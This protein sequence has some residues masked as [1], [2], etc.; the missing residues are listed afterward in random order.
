MCVLIL[1]LSCGTLLLF[2]AMLHLKRCIYKCPSHFHLPL[3]P[4]FENTFIQTLVSISSLTDTLLRPLIQG[5][6]KVLSTLAVTSVKWIPPIVTLSICHP[7]VYFESAHCPIAIASDDE[8]LDAIHLLFP[9]LFF[10]EL[11][12]AV[13]NLLNCTCNGYFV[14]STSPRVM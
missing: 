11:S 7:C 2:G 6:I 13:Y 12:K 8:V 9:L 5:K 4:H 1:L 14:L 3:K 10:L